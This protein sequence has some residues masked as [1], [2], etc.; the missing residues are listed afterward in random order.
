MSE[1]YDVIIIG[2][3]PA[4]IFAAL[5]L[6]KQSGTRVL[7]IEK[8]SDIE[9]RSCPMHN[10]NMPCAQCEICG[11]LCGWGGAGAY[12]DG[13]LTLTSAFG[14]WLGEYLPAEELG[15]LIEYV[16]AVYCRFGAGKDIHG[17]DREAVERLR[18][19]ARSYDLE[20]VPARI[21]HIGT[22]LCKEVLKNIRCHLEGKV[23]VLFN[24]PVAQI[25]T[26]RGE[27]AGVVTGD[28]KRY[29]GRFIVIA[30][31]REGSSWLSGEA[32]RL[33]LSLQTNPVDIGVRV[34]LPASIMKD[35]TDITYEAKFLYT[36][37]KFHDRIRTFCMNPYG[38]VVRENSDG[39]F[40]V[41]G[42]SY[43]DMR[44]GNTNF[45]LLVSTDFT[46][47]FH[48]PITYGKYIAGLANLLSGG[49]LVQRLGDLKMGRRS[50][51]ERIVEGSV[52]P[53]LGDATP[54]DLSFVLPYRHLAAILEM[55]EVLDNVAPGVNSGDTLLYGVEVK[56]YSM[57]LKLTKVL[58]TEI[59]NLYAVGDGAGV[60]RGLIQS[61]VSGIV[62]TREI[63]KRR[64]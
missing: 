39:V 60:T 36:T 21:R 41:N 56:Y 64:G 35:I 11:I 57:R 32:K 25:I 28:G 23:T 33:G 18:K 7:M 24:T 52:R 46:K 38:E 9:A 27:V 3:G 8:G 14:G 10:A 63:E 30:V 62:V 61:S 13:K 43:K 20:L 45:A 44:T 31:G 47:P 6:L 5:E 37:K 15:Q 34:E 4:G 59:K 19:K 58:E 40:S 1:R 51:P 49:V 42:H 29:E 50:T 2:A 17:E 48:E 26:E 16:D 54:G 22:D 53:T 55:L 12:S